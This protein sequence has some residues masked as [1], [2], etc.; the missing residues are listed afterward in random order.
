MNTLNT[1]EAYQKLQ[2]TQLDVKGVGEIN[3]ESDSTH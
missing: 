3:T 1:N 2:A